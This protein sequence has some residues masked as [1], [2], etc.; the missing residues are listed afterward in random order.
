MS[1][2]TVSLTPASSASNVAPPAGNDNNAAGPGAFHAM[3]SEQM[4]GGKTPAK[5]APKKGSETNQTDKA[6][7][8]GEDKTD[9]G[10][11]GQSGEIIPMAAVVVLNTP[12][13]AVL[14]SSLVETEVAID[15]VAGQPQARARRRV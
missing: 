7:V 15:V 8:K 5:C 10:A 9:A 12:I 6:S 2:L 3:L 14:P 11:T 13:A 4:S 1:I